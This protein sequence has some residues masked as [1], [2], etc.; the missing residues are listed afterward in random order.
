MVVIGNNGIESDYLKLDMC[1]CVADDGRKCF[2]LGWGSGTTM[3][4]YQ[5]PPLTALTAK[6]NEL[7]IPIKLH[8]QI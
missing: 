5:V 2:T 4:N 7:N 6:A 8:Q 1:R 3:F